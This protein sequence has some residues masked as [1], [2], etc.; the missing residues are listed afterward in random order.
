MDKIKTMRLRLSILPFSS[1]NVA[2][3]ETE[4]PSVNKE[5]DP[6]GGGVK[7]GEGERG[8][9]R[10]KEST[11]INVSRSIPNGDGR[12]KGCGGSGK[13]GRLSSPSSS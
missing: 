6:G 13:T 5:G 11:R 7:A 8:R 3:A 9:G 2:S 1:P 10:P 4:K 12:G